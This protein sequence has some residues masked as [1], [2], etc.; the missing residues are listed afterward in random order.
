MPRSQA[1]SKRSADAGGASVSSGEWLPGA[2]G[3]EITGTGEEPRAGVGD[4]SRTGSSDAPLVSTRCAC[5]GGDLDGSL[6]KI[7]SHLVLP[8]GESLPRESRLAGM[9]QEWDK[10]CVGK[11]TGELVLGDRAV[12]TLST[13]GPAGR[14]P[15]SD[16]CLAKGE[17]PPPGRT[18][19]EPQLP[20]ELG[21]HWTTLVSGAPAP[22][23]CW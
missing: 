11:F 16:A 10:P 19:G 3:R 7:G 14:R 1:R 23:A 6:A 13:S 2:A 15:A 9:E 21:G 4:P 20:L 8:G 5:G 17:A 22:D 18:P 12:W